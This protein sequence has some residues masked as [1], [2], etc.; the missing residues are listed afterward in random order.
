M[1]CVICKGDNIRVTNVKEELKSGADL[2][3]IPIVIPVCQ[4]CGE[5]YYDRRTMELLEKAAM[6]LH[7]KKL[8]VRQIGRVLEPI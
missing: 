8:E 1:K 7:E 4:T 3:F 5:R 2:V 6:N